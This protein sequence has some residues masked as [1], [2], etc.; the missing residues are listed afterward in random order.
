IVHR[1]DMFG[2]AQ[3]YQ[4]RGRVGRSKLRA[5]AYFTTPPGQRLTE[6]ADKRLKVLQSLD[7]LGAGFALASHDLDIRGAGNLLGEEQSGH[8]REVG[9][10]L[11]QSMLEETIASVKGGEM[12]EMDE[13]W[14][15]QI[16]L[17]TSVLIPEPYVSDLQ[18]RLG[19]YR[20]LSNLST[21]EEIDAF[22]AELADRFGPLPEEVTQLLEIVEIKA[23]CRRA[24]V[25]TVDAGPKGA[26][27]SFRKGRF[28]NPQALM[29]YIQGEKPGLVKLQPDM[30]LLVKGEWDEADRRLKGARALVRR[31]AEMAE[32]AAKAA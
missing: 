23:L 21:R 32:A 22:A 16:S 1:A 31:L 2:L 26:T 20:R 28:A 18:L 13:A 15:P 9:F 11:Y 12:G 3:L 24:G 6:G 30:R 4:L 10:E 5:Y 14:S 17:G 7:T 8:I 27:V 29:A 25:A 19:L